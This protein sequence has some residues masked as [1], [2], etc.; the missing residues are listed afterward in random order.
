MRQVVLRLYKDLLRYGENLKYTDKR[1]FRTRIR[2]SF[3][4]NK[5]LTDQAQID[6]QLKVK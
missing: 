1:Y 2:N 6:F 3:R 5:E 4:G